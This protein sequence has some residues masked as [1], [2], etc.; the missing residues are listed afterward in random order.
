MFETDAKLCSGKSIGEKIFEGTRGGSL[1]TR[2]ANPPFERSAE[3]IF[4]DLVSCDSD[5][6]RL[7]G[8]PETRYN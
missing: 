4:E 1:S 8:M 6:N 5:N 2:M 7:W 3:H